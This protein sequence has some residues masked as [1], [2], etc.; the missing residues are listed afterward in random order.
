MLTSLLTCAHLLPWL[1]CCIWIVLQLD[2]AVQR[3]LI[4]EGMR[5]TFKHLALGR[6]RQ[7]PGQGVPFV[8]GAQ[9]QWARCAVGSAA[10]VV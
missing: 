6:A 9:G 4:P 7:T 5:L 8:V 10:G 3:V 1:L 2:F